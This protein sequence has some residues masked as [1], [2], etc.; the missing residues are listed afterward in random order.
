M[1]EKQIL[2]CDDAAT[3]ARW[4][5]GNHATADAVWL[6]IVKKGATHPGPTYA[7]ALDEALCFGWIDSQKAALDAD[8]SLQRFGRRGPRSIWSKRNQEHVSRLIDEGRMRPA[9]LAEIERAK[10]NGRWETAYAG[11][12]SIEVPADLAAALA[13]R[14]AA[15]AFFDTLNGTNRFAILFRL[16][17]VVRAETRARKITEYVAMLER[18]ETLHPQPASRAPRP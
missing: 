2:R 16:G 6:T 10:A 14:P 13:A 12:A 8:F 11:Q 9:G 15:S 4:L 18:G 7:E 3:W 1:P 17:N 5:A